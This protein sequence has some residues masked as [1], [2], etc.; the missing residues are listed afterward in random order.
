MG[1]MFTEDI[2]RHYVG[3]ERVSEKNLILIARLFIIAIVVLTFLCSLL[4][5]IGIETP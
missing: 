5:S 3:K 4:N 2:V 1:T